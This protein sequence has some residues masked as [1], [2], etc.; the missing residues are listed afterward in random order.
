MS[1]EIK[2]LTCINCPLGCSLLV[3]V[4]GNEVISVKGNTCPRGEEYGRNEVINPKRV[5]TSSVYV[6][7]GERNVVSVKTKEAIAKDKIFDCVEAMKELKV[8]APVSI[9]DVIAED[10]AG[11]GVELIATADCGI[12]L[13]S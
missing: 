1:T 4:D 5:V 6:T 8:E 12:F 13:T 7:N 2:K 10:I 3:E 9:G 11:T